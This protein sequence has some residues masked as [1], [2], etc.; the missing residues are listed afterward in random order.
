MCYP[1]LDPMV[2]CGATTPPDQEIADEGAEQPEPAE[3]AASA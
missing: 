1:G 2:M 3:E